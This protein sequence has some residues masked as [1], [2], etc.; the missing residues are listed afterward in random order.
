MKSSD[1]EDVTRLVVQA[2]KDRLGS[3]DADV[4]EVVT[5]E[6]VSAMAGVNRVP[7]PSTP[8]PPI[9]AA[10]AADNGDGTLTTGLGAVLPTPAGAGASAELCAGCLEQV[11]REQH[12]RA[13]V[14]T[15][16][17]NAK[18]VVARVA[19]VV[20]DPGGDIQDISQTIVGDFFTM[21]M[22]VDI[23]DLAV[24]FAEFRE[25]VLAAARD[26]GIQA[27]VMHEE[28]LLALQRV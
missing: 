20:A 13:V 9:A 8:A 16:G 2:V 21:I 18:G 11:R 4:V 15:T 22:V 1:I 5:R 7:A 28:V 17:R 26:L 10:T 25:R 27:M 6:V 14:T 3:H 23:T 24:P 12:N 19:T